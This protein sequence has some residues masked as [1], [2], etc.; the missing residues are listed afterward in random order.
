[1]LLY[2]LGY[3]LTFLHSHTN[4]SNQFSAQLK[5]A[6][7]LYVRVDEA[8]VEK[9]KSIKTIVQ[10]LSSKGRNEA[11][12]SGKALLYFQK[13]E[14]AL[15]LKYGDELILK[16]SLFEIPAIKNPGAFDYKRFMAHKNIYLQGNIK[17][18]QWIYTGR[19]KGNKFI[20]QSIVMRNQLLSI[21][22]YA[23]LQGDELAVASAL[24]VGYT[25]KLE[26][27]LLSAYSQTGVLHILSVSGLHVGIVF[28]ALNTLLIFME[29]FKYGSILKAFLLIF[30]LWFY[31][32]ITG[33]S[34]SVM[35]SAT[36]FSF[37]IYAKTFKKNS[38][39]YNTIF[40][41]A[42]VL[43]LYNPL[44]IVDVGFQLSYVAVIGIVY[45]QPVF[46]NFVKTDNRILNKFISLITV[47]IAAQLATF[48]ISIYYFHQFPNY[49]L[50]S[51][52]IAIPISSGVIYLGIILMLFSGNAFLLKFI[53]SVFSIAIHLLNGSIRWV[54]QLPYA[55]TNCIFINIA[56]MVVLYVSVIFLICFVCKKKC[57]YLYFFL[58]SIISFLI[59]QLVNEIKLCNQR[60]F[61]VYAVPKASM[62]DF[63][64]EKEHVL[65]VDSAKEAD[66]KLNGLKSYWMQ[67]KLGNP[68]L[69]SNAAKTQSVYIKDQ[70]IQFYDRRMVILKNEEPTKQL[71]KTG[72][73]ISVDY[74]VLSDNVKLSITEI[75]SVYHPR[76]IIFDS[77]NN[78]YRMKEWG[79]I[80]VEEKQQYFSVINT[81]AF[82]VEF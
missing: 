61:I 73:G 76:V 59:I 18:D 64:Y 66:Q 19:N 77:S 69:T 82:I 10:L 62:I 15:K 79:N 20:A 60:K 54:S 49:F 57:S 67:L 50:L 78:A 21:L 42:F 72:N 14:R 29:K 5:N 52:L 23:Q 43:L 27:E 63:I 2:A 28:V 35:R 33:L 70:F 44:F 4:T 12:V 48:P 11:P 6:S 7:F 1:M 55:I 3:Q 9:E 71:C 47:S 16:N 53:S 36:M 31:A 17:A 38:T 22:K 75:K 30:F 34:P 37:I 8:V 24:L 58:F 65:L 81:G 41:S 51:N 45:I 74:A 32:F 25:D 56:Q 80:C 68:I 40:A 13:D 26:A 46:S 39:I